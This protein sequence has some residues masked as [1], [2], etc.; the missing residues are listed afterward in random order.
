MFKITTII[1]PGD[2]RRAMSEL[3][4]WM[5]ATHFRPQIRSLETKCFLYFHF[6][7]S[8]MYFGIV[9]P[10]WWKAN[11]ISSEKSCL[12]PMPLRTVKLFSRR[13]NPDCSIQISRAPALCKK[14]KCIQCSF[15]NRI[16]LKQREYTL[17]CF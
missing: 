4:F 7:R 13:L 5:P 6:L 17:E 3:P 2:T 11:A 1:L 15:L 12:I 10:F 16:F 8:D 14:M 9:N